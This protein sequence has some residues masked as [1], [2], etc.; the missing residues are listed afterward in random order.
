MASYSPLVAHRC[1]TPYLNFEINSNVHK[2][3]FT[4]KLGYMLMESICHYVTTLVL[5]RG[6]LVGSYGRLAAL[7]SPVYYS[8]LVNLEIKALGGRRVR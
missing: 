3:N 2:R 5:P 1:V 4:L 8:I 6:P 7:C